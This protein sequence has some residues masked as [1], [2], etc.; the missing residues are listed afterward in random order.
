MTSARRIINA[1]LLFAWLHAH[2]AAAA[3][4][5]LIKRPLDPFTPWNVYSTVGGSF[6]KPELM[7]MD[8][9]LFIFI[10]ICI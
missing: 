8:L 1:S 7:L 9:Y 2:Y 4:Y 10:I 3:V 5:G 6:L